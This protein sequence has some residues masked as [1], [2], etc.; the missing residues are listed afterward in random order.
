[1]LKFKPKDALEKSVLKKDNYD[2]IVQ[3]MEEERLSRPDVFAEPE[4]F[5]L[6]LEAAMMLA[7]IG[8]PKEMRQEAIDVVREK[9]G[10]DSEMFEFLSG[11]FSQ[12][13]NQAEQ[14]EEE[15]R[16]LR[17]IREKDEQVII[18]LID[19]S[20]YYINNPLPDMDIPCLGE[21]SSTVREELFRHGFYTRPLILLLHKLISPESK[22]ID[23]PSEVMQL[24]YDDRRAMI[25]EIMPVL[26]RQEDDDDVEE[27]IEDD[28]ASDDEQSHDSV[29]DV[30]CL[31]AV[32]IIGKYLDSMN[33]QYELDE[34]KCDFQFV[35]PIDESFKKYY[36]GICVRERNILMYAILP[37]QCPEDRRQAV[38]EYLNR[39]NYDLVCGNFEMDMSTGELRFRQCHRTSTFILEKE[40]AYPLILALPTMVFKQYV[41]GLASVITG[42][43]TPEE[44]FRQAVSNEKERE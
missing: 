19:E 9:C 23:I 16:L 25:N 20:E 10:E 3:I 37:F 17:A 28:A 42:R 31:R 8:L 35:V 5:Q 11:E 1:M 40:E 44:A 13:E 26:L 27:D 15:T 39:V 30:R 12:C 41:A 43:R 18:A 38:A 34:K 14:D 6:T 29:D 4:T 24:E 22:D 32:D 2:V 36:S 33:I 21:L 7:F